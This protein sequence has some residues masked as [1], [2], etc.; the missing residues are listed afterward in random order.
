VAVSTLDFFV[1]M[2]E[3]FNN[4]ITTERLKSGATKI[5]ESEILLLSTWLPRKHPMA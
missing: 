5:Y 3:E 2:A 4:N 1:F